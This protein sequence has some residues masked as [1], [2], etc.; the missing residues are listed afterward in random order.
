MRFTTAKEA[1]NP[2]A[3]F[4]GGHVEGARI[5]FEEMRE[6]PLQLARDHVFGKLLFN[7]AFVVL[8]NFDDAVDRTVDVFLKHVANN[9]RKPPMRYRRRGNSRLAY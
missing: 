3:D 6:M 7:G 4:I 8:G 1:R 5:T 9:H 2:H